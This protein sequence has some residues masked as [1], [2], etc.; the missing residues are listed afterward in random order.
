MAYSKI[1][2]FLLSFGIATTAAAST[3]SGSGG[4][5]DSGYD[6][7][8]DTETQGTD[9]GY[10][11]DSDGATTNEWCGDNCSAAGATPTILSPADGAIVDATFH[12]SVAIPPL[13]ACDT[14]GCNDEQAA[15]VNVLV[16]GMSSTSCGDEACWQ[17]GFDLTLA[18]GEHT[19]ELY[20]ESGFTGSNSTPIVVVVQEG[21]VEPET[22]GAA[23][24]EPETTGASS[25]AEEE[26]DLESRG[27]TCNAGD[28]SPAALLFLVLPFVLR[29]RAQV[30]IASSS[31]TTT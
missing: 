30:A 12:L 13:C 22:T 1:A 9:T 18:P 25:P 31:R 23:Q 24:P 27:C 10:S 3:G 11:T 7:G 6:G 2:A 26:E 19:I 17:R 8:D 15:Y 21:P 14:C 5:G 16:D 20:T 29:R 4:Y 28:P